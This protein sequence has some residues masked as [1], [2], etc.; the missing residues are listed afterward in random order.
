MK[1]GARHQRSREIAAAFD[2]AAGDYHAHARV[3]PLVAAR[4]LAYLDPLPTPD[5]IL[6]LG[7]GTGGLS[8]QL[9]QRFPESTLL[10]SD[11]AP[12]MVRT[13]RCYL[14]TMGGTTRFVVMDGEQPAI[15]GARFDLI[16]SS[17]AFQWFH[18]LA[19]ACHTLTTLL[20]PGG[21]LLFSTLGTDTFREWRDLC[22][23]AG[24][25][26]GTPV[27]PSAN[28][29]ESCLG[30]GW[31]REEYRHVTHGSVLEFLRSLKQL[32]ANTPR[33]G[34]YPAEVAGLRP[35]LG[36]GPLE[37]TYHVLYGGYQRYDN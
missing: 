18:D 11:I 8:G 37:V 29:L 33:A 27:F 9:R 7:C 2:R 1:D 34:H 13:C 19:A 20:R 23:T 22:T 5:H 17:L 16:I 35:V 4:L 14:Q 10:V 15:T 32:G 24:I 30:R 31:V 6:E 3:Q 25:P 36:T 12:A 28:A 21:T 26:C